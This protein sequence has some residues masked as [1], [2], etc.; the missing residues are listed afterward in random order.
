[1]EI[2]SHIDVYHFPGEVSN[3][4]S[5]WGFGPGLN[6]APPRGNGHK[7]VEMQSE[8]SHGGGLSAIPRNYK[9]ADEIL[10]RPPPDRPGAPQERRRP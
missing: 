6:A 8:A 4:V 9:R 3:Q 1:M 2:H 7:P 5:A 10:A